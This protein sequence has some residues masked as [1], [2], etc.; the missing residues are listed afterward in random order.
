MPMCGTQHY[1]HTGDARDRLYAQNLTEDKKPRA[2]DEK[3]IPE[4]T[5]GSLV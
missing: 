2:L 4:I 3:L 1:R 5:A